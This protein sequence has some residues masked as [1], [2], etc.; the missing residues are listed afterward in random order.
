MKNA[1]KST[2][3]NEEWKCEV[4]QADDST[5]E[6]NVKLGWRV[7]ADIRDEFIVE[8]I[9]RK[10]SYEQAIALA[11]QLWL[12]HPKPKWQFETDEDTVKAFDRFWNKPRGETDAK[13]R[14]ALKSL[15][16]ERY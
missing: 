12:G 8:A 13:I 2:G 4:V 7:P 6:K 15:L 5:E 14:D 1:I 11:M 16:Q 9:R 3:R 10:L